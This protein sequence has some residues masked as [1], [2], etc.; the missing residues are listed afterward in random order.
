LDQAV[1]LVVRSYVEGTL[2]RGKE[3]V[4]GLDENAVGIAGISPEV[5]ESVRREVARTAARLRAGA[6]SG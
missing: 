5:P 3:L 2:P 6:A 1:L 4:L